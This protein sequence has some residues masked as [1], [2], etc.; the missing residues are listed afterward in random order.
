[1]L[2]KPIAAIALSLALASN[3][4]FAAS[5]TK[6]MT[7]EQEAK[8]QDCKSKAGDKKGKE[9]RSFMRECAGEAAAK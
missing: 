7:P 6:K 2:I 8:M 4:A 5:T 9:L 3:L 1:M